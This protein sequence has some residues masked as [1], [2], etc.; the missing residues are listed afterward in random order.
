M[1]HSSSQHSSAHISTHMSGYI[2]LHTCLDTFLQTCLHTCLYTCLHKRLYMSTHTSTHDYTHVYTQLGTP[3]HSMQLGT[4]FWLF[5]FSQSVV[6]GETLLPRRQRSRAR[7]AWHWTETTR[8]SSPTPRITASDASSQAHRRSLPACAAVGCT[9]GRAAAAVMGA[10]PRR[11]PNYRHPP[12][13][14]THVKC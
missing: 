12:L 11:Q 6:F 14:T 5:V 10:W 9:V 8:C 2:S 3:C 13:P 1:Q 7:R 4:A